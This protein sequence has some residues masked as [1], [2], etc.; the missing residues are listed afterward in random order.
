MNI[1]TKG[2][3]KILIFLITDD[4]FMKQIDKNVIFLD[5]HSYI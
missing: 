3:E 2:N 1:R 4:S 5:V